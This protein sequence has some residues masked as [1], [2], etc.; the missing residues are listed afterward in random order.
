MG[1][2]RLVNLTRTFDEVTAVD[3]LD[4][5]IREREF[6][7]LVGPSGC[8]KTTVLRMIAGLQEPTAG[9]IWIGDRMVNDVSPRDRDIA[10]VFQNYA[11]YPHMT[12]AENLSFGLRL[13]KLP[14]EEIA[15]RVQETAQMLQIDRLLDRLPAEL[16]GGQRQRVALGRA[17]IRE[18]VCF[19]MDEPLSN[20]DARLRVQTRAELIR[21]HRRLGITTIYV[22]HDQVEAMTM[23]DRIAVMRD[24]RLQQVGQPAE[25]YRTP[26]NMFV[27][28]FIG[29]PPM[30]F[31]TARVQDDGGAIHLT[32]ESFDLHLSESPES[33]SQY[34]GGEVVVGIRPTDLKLA[35]DPTQAC[36]IEATLV[37]PEPTGAET[38]LYLQL[39][40]ESLV[41][42]VDSDRQF[43][44]GQQLKLAVDMS[45]AHL[46]DPSS[47]ERIT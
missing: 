15:S 17:I 10:M 14:H 20:L 28:G 3:G 23:G 11:L 38:V 4:L 8:G 12:V 1:F 24:G 6:L 46:F 33:A 45:R 47:E 26:A 42:S 19:L 31:L 35:E 36:T 29:S 5:Q 41:A 25:V 21:L 2:V 18:P 34:L 7:V 40:G 16:S 22:T 9:E 43:E 27:A 37:V 30:N 39:G 13:R 44:E 32:G